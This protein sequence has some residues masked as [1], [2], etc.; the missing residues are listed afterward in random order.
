[1]SWMITTAICCNA[2]RE[3]FTVKGSKRYAVLDFTDVEQRILTLNKIDDRIQEDLLKWKEEYDQ[4]HRSISIA[5]S[6]Y[7][8]AATDQKPLLGK[9]QTELCQILPRR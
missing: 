4:A 9:F 7:L 8:G 2:T 6:R 3:D 5:T 1:M